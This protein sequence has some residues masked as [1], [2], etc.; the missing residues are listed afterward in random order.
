VREREE[1]VAE[2]K[3]WTKISLA[4]R[5]IREELWAE[6]REIVGRGKE[7]DVKEELGLEF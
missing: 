1:I 2:W 7:A 6:V 3:T 4:R 5:R